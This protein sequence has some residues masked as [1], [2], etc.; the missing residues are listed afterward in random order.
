[1]NNS[2]T[3]FLNE[4][5]SLDE[6]NLD[7][8]ENSVPLNRKNS[9]IKDK[10]TETNNNSIA[11]EITQFPS[12]MES[13]KQSIFKETQKTTTLDTTLQVENRINK[14]NENI[15]EAYS[16]KEALISFL[17][18][19]NKVLT[20][21]K[22]KKIQETVKMRVFKKNSFIKPVD[23][24]FSDKIEASE[25]VNDSDS[26]VLLDI[27][28]ELSQTENN[29]LDFNDNNLNEIVDGY[30][31]KENLID[32]DDDSNQINER[33]IKVNKNKPDVYKYLDMEAECSDDECDSVT[34]DENEL[35][36]FVSKN[37]ESNE[38]AF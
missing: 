28:S 26:T 29:E 4:L 10:L 27:S 8:M 7:N 21:L 31:N 6:F 2:S 35:N 11:F 19:R 9:S 17:P 20:E 32:K 16:L 22:I 18:L 25:K 14:N 1:M 15:Y 36:S 33:N 13:L 5:N 12:S 38:N 24:L 23:I 30:I 3:D 37:E 34:E